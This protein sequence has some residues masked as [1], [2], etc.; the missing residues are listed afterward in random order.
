MEIKW[1]RPLPTIT[2]T[3][4]S[5]SLM[6]GFCETMT[7]LS[8][9]WSVVQL[10]TLIAKCCSAGSMLRVYL[11]TIVYLYIYIIRFLW[12]D[13]YNLD[14][15]SVP[16]HALSTNCDVRYEPPPPGPKAQYIFI[17]LSIYVFISIFFSKSIYPSI[18]FIYLSMNIS[19]FIYKYEF[20][21]LIIRYVPPVPHGSP[22]KKLW[23][24]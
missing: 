9:W 2:Q 17:Y 12:I 1:T 4:I 22:F 16:M 13:I 14:M 24:T 10:P 23:S 11:K 7:T 5:N 6:S 19:I 8:T 3:C 15:L 21:E 20:Y 18:Y